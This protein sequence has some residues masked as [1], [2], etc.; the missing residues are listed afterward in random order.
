MVWS[1]SLKDMTSTFLV[2]YMQLNLFVYGT[3][4]QPP[5]I[6]IV[7]FSVRIQ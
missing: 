6:V 1:C 2:V 3:D 5:A 7:R 4:I